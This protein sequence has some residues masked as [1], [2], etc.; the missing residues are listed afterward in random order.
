MTAARSTQGTQSRSAAEGAGST[1]DVRQRRRLLRPPGLLRTPGLLRMLGVLSDRDFRLLWA[2]ESTS[3]LGSSIGGVS[4][5]LAALIVLHASVFAVSMLTAAA[6]LPWLLIGLPAGAWVDRLP[7]RRIMISAD[8]VSLGAFASVPIAAWCGCLT[9]FQLLIVAF[10]GGTATVFFKTAYRAFLPSVI[11]ADKLLEGNAKLQGSE[12]V[13]N[14]AGP[15]AAGLI[16]QAAGAILGVLTDA[17][18]F[19][20]SAFCLTRIQVQEPHQERAPAAGKRNLRA[21][22]AEG[23]AVVIRDPLLRVTTI[24]GCL[25]N[26]LLVGYQ[27]VLIVFLVKVVGLNAGGAGLLLALTSLGGVGGALLA[28]TAARRFGTARATLYCKMG[29]A[30]AGLLI[31]LAGRGPGLA[32]FVL[33]SIALVGGIIAGNIIWSGFVQSYY[34]AQLL[35]RVTTSTQVFNYGAIPAGAVVAGLLASH[36]GVRLALWIMLGGLALSGGVL[37]LSPLPRMRDL[38]APPDPPSET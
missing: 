1:A 21:D 17:A 26:F 32:L 11:S 36:V 31:P 29:L 20:V 19:A 34:P 23:L 7:R 10:A 27:S 35:G 14:V 8:L 5:P 16:A 30:P 22:I 38:P 28:R 25:S 2:G 12:Q 4:L 33:G 9:I 6:W 13:A 24:Y 37:L 15:G 3:C 18:S